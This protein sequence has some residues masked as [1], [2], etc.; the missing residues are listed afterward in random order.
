VIDGKVHDFSAGGLF[1]GL[2][3]LI[4]DQTETY[5]D[6]ITGEAV[7]GPLAGKKMECWPIFI[8]TA[9]AELANHPETRFVPM[10]PP[11]KGKLMA[12]VHRRKVDSGGFIPPPFFNTMGEP[13]TRLDRN[14]QGLGVMVD[15]EAR[16]YRTADLSEPVTDDWGGRT[17]RLAR[18]EV[19]RV[20]GARWEDDGTIPF[21]LFT[22]WYGFSY[23]FPGCAIYGR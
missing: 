3:L 22:R 8:T 15:G 2:V 1:N 21:Q 10:K 17:L 23:T 13:D 19:D 7:H 16:F 20:P 12:V 6:H 11:L 4:D 9:E 5:W 18:G 14:E